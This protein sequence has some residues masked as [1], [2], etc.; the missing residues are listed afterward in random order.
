[1]TDWIKQGKLAASKLGGHWVVWERDLEEFVKRRLLF[2]E[3]A[4]LGMLFFRSSVLEQYRKDS[5]YYVHEAGFHGRVGNKEERYRMHQ[6]RSLTKRR[7]YTWSKEFFGKNDYK[8][9]D[10]RS[11][12]ELIFWKIRRA[13]GDFTLAIDPRAFCLVPESER[14][15]W[16]AF[17]IHKPVF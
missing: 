1:M 3:G 16:E 2:V 15:K 11:F 7:P 14:K 10:S 17:Q 6:A 4:A 5:R 8:L 9:M 12:A 13:S